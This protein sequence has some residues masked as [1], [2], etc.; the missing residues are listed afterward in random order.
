MKH[1]NDDPV[2]QSLQS[3]MSVRKNFDERKSERKNLFQIKSCLSTRLLICI[4]ITLII[5]VIKLIIG[6]IYHTHCSIRSWIANYVIVSA[7]IEISITL[8][9]LLNVF[10]FGAIILKPRRKKIFQ[11]SDDKRHVL[12]DCASLALI[13]IVTWCIIIILVEIITGGVLV[14]SVK[15]FVQFTDS[16][17]TKTY[18][19][20]VL[21]NCAFWTLIIYCG[22]FAALFLSCFV[23][24]AK[25][26][27]KD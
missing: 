19:H 13:S 12:Y 20:P 23:Y 1:S 26:L 25:I 6:I 22:I 24:T 8:L 9:F 18:C 7:V 21:Y 14:F 15:G 3:E 17:M 2:F 27:C 11:E 4:S 5:A 16:T 10:L